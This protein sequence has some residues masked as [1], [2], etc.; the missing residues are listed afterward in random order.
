MI[1]LYK[2]IAKGFYNSNQLQMIFIM[3]IYC[4]CF[5]FYKNAFLQ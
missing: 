1:F 5:F 3:K 4:K 2:C